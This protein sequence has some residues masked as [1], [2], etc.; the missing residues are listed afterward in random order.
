MTYGEIY[1]DFL[2]D[3]Q[4]KNI[5]NGFEEYIKTATTK[6][7]S[8]PY[9]K[10]VIEFQIYNKPEWSLLE[11]IINKRITE[12]IKKYYHTIIYYKNSTIIDP[13][14]FIDYG[15]NLQRIKKQSG[16]IE[17]HN[18]DNNY[19]VDNTGNVPYSFSFIIFLNKINEGGKICF[20]DK[21]FDTKAGSI[22]FF[23]TDWCH[24]MKITT[25]HDDNLYSITGFVHIIK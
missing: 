13:S 1:N 19:H 9:Y 20:L 2:T 11:K 7:I 15:Y 18:Y 10:N 22:L 16:C 4:C 14:G 25:P 8:Y 21:E 24:S 23:P 3:V 6:L 12:Y 17:L 5:V